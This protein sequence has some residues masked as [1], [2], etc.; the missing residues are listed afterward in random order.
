MDPDNDRLS[1]HSND[2][3][4]QAVVLGL[5]ISQAE[6]SDFTF[7]LDG[8]AL[9]GGQVGF[10]FDAASQSVIVEDDNGSESIYGLE[11]LRINPDGTTDSFKGEVS[12]AGGP[13]I[14]LGLGADWTGRGAP[15]AFAISGGTL[16]TPAVQPQAPAQDGSIVLQSMNYTDRYLAVS[17]DGTRVE[18][19]PV[20]A[21]SAPT[22]LLR[23]RF[24]ATPMP[25]IGEDVVYLMVND[26]SG[27]YLV[28]TR[29]GVTLQSDG[30]G[31]M[32][33]FFRVVTGLDGQGVSFVSLE[34]PGSYLRHSGFVLRLDPADGSPLFDQDATFLPGGAVAQ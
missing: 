11:I 32:A 12:D 25:D 15:P 14:G 8:V 4:P 6:G 31:G 21:A 27:R 13:G 20:T 19:V 2:G 5:A 29:E 28:A 24:L 23:S 3:R 30:G 17:E 34:E 16:L 26:G 7:N 33:A 22:L 9:A 1:L 10:G 18:L